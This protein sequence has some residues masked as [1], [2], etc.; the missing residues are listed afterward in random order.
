MKMTFAFE[1]LEV[2][3]KAVVWVDRVLRTAEKLDTEQRHYRLISQLE[4]A[5][6]SVPMNVARPVE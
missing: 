5:A 1:N 6:T 4:S 2:W 3:Q